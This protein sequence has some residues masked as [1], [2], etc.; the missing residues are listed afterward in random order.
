VASVAVGALV[1]T[2][3]P[4]NVGLV[5]ATGIVA[6]IA[7]ITV[8]ERR[9]EVVLGA[10]IFI[11]PL[12]KGENAA[13]G[14]NRGELATVFMLGIASLTLATPRRAVDPNLR[15]LVLALAALGC[16]G[17][18]A[19]AANHIYAPSVLAASAMKPIA[20]AVVSYLVYVYFDSREK[21]RALVLAIIAS[22]TLVGVIGILQHVTGRAV[23][24][25]SGGPPRVDS[26][27]EH[28]NQLGGFMALLAIPTL[29]Y[30]LSTKSPLRKTLLIAACGVQLAALLLS[31]TL[32]S[33][34]GL[35]VAGIVA[36]RLWGPHLRLGLTL[37]ILP[38]LATVVLS[39]LVPELA[40][41]VH[42]ARNRATDR[43]STYAAGIKLARDNPLFG[44]G[45]IGRATEEIQQNTAY[46]YSRFGETS[47]Q[48]HNAFISMLVQS[49]IFAFLFLC[50]AAWLSMRLFF[51]MR[52]PPDSPD[53]VLHWGILLG[54]I[55]FLVQNLTNSLIIHA[56]LGLVF[57]VLVASVVRLREFSLEGERGPGQER[58]GERAPCDAGDVRS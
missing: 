42:L 3:L 33:G 49:G 52:P 26:T 58:R 14:L 55:A 31:A 43:L 40:D 23:V 19:S 38:L 28:W 46:R 29:T 47:V 50:W 21:L 53:Y 35:L 18:L 45:S 5:A 54:G 8:W 34:V 57:F 48:P 17:A 25:P 41:R 36:V 30:A 10:F 44:T 27:F 1:A 2:G 37:T 15:R 16:V 13:L 9:P 39:L 6:L 7:T 24:P 11:L 51:A 4:G 12:L 32:G 20:W 56:R 22:G